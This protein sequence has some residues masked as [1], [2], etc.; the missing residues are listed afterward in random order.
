VLAQALQQLREAARERAELVA[1]RGAGHAAPYLAARAERG[2]GRV[3][4]A[5]HAQRQPRGVTD[6]ARPDDE[7]GEQRE[8]H[9]ACERAIRERQDG[10]ARLLEHHGAGRACDRHCGCDDRL[11]VRAAAIPGCRRSSRER[12]A[13][14]L[15]GD[16]ARGLLARRR[17]ILALEQPA[18]Q[19]AAQARCL[20]VRRLRRHASRNREDPTVAVEHAQPAVV[21]AELAE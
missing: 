6:Q 11:A 3:R 7:G 8:R 10:L 5:P 12:P 1:G 13:Q 18:K 15:V 2:L 21:T 17:R 19:R 4:E 14:R 20:R 9:E 16:T